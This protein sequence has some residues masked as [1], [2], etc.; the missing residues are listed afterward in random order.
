MS[1][2][3]A[4]KTAPLPI[5]T[6]SDFIPHEMPTTTE[7]ATLA[8][9]LIVGDKQDPKAYIGAVIGAIWLWDEA[10]RQLP[11]LRDTL[12]R[13]HAIAEL[14]AQL[15]PLVHAWPKNE[16]G[17]NLIVPYAEAIDSMFP[18]DKKDRRDSLMLELL[19]YVASETPPEENIGRDNWRRLKKQG[20]NSTEFYAISLSLASW[21]EHMRSIAAQQNAKK[22]TAKKPKK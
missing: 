4:K 15:P 21:R 5:A 2:K 3:P 13:R 12:Y 8:I 6:P 20:F 17:E 11:K 22:R 19:N 18:R 9:P 10:H 7:I 1:T 16:E 14:S